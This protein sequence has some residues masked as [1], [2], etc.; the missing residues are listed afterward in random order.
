MPFRYKLEGLL[1]L[2]RG[3]E[4]QE[5]NRLLA[6]AAKLAALNHELEG[7]EAVGMDRK[8]AAQE[9]MRS[10]VLAAVLK[11]GMAWEEAARKK[12]NELKAQRELARKARKEQLERYRAARQNR[13]VLESLKDRQRA[14]YESEDARRAQQDLDE[15]HLTQR[16]PVEIE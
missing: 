2:Q 5:E 4:K 8:R 6:C 9:E 13:E 1:R 14:A 7:L 3:R 15:M 12:A 16:K 11:I 10:G